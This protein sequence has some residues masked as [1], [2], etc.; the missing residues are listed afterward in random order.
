[1]IKLKNMNTIIMALLILLSVSCSKKDPITEVIGNNET[2]TTNHVGQYQ[3]VA[4]GQT[5][6]FGNDSEISQ[7]QK[8]D[9]FYGQDAQFIKNQA[10]YT[11][12]G[13][14][15]ITDNV[16]GLMWQKSYEVMTYA[17]AVKVVK[18][19]NLAGYSDWRLPT[20]K[21]L[22]SLM[23]FSGADPSGAES[24]E[25]PPNGKPNMNTEGAIPFIDTVYF[26]FKF[27]SNGQREID[28][29]LL[30]STIYKGKTMMNNETVF[31]LNVADGR[32]KGY[33]LI[34]PRTQSGKQFTVRFVR[35]N[36]E[37][38]KNN[39]A[40][41]DGVI[42]DKATGLIWSKD[43]SKRGM[44]W[45]EALAYA[46]QKNK[47]NYLGYSDWRLPNAKELQ[48][49]VDYNRSPQ[50][51]HSPAIDPIFDTSTITDEGGKTNY[52]F[53]WTSTTHKN[54]KQVSWAVYICFGEGLGFFAPPHNAQNKE[55][56]DVHGAGAQRSD[57]KT[58]NATDYPQGHGPQGDVVRVN[59]YVRLVRNL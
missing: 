3:I 22:Y 53:F 40:E 7:P 48:S 16:T 13:N 47:E 38:G 23:D 45:E 29:Q 55:L 20:I 10:S 5:K 12:N 6:F 42:T 9:P 19:F 4:T 51:T 50:Q 57:P 43:D 39:F 58:G 32:I 28:T 2:S 52:P 36:I 44:N 56:M 11:N 17:E 33:E 59:N 37:Y 21:E 49:I 31:G 54:V 41:K 35:G 15:T 46:E 34:D 1:M 30:S 25:E 24:N 26:D 27:G 14:S 18:T 8:G